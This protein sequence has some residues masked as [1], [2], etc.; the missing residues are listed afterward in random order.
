MSPNMHPSQRPVT[1]KNQAI[2]QTRP[3]KPPLGC[4]GTM[5]VQD[6]PFDAVG[7]GT[8]GPSPKARKGR[9]APAKFGRTGPPTVKGHAPV[10]ALSLGK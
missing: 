5:I 4:S 1:R 3:A 6:H 8:P 2:T 7:R 10:S 9:E